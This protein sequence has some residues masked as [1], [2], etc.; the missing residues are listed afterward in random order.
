MKNR[1]AE[2]AAAK[3]D[4]DRTRAVMQTVLDNMGEGVMLFDADIRCQFANRQLMKL[5]ELPP[6]LGRPGVSLE[7]ITR[8]MAKRGDF[9]PTADPEATSRARL[10]FLLKESGIRYERRTPSGR[11]VEFTFTPLA[12]ESL[13]CVARDVTEVKQR[14]EALPAAADMLKLISRANFDLRAVLDTLVRTAARLC[15]ADWRRQHPARRRYVPPD[16][17][18]RLLARVRPSSSR[19]GC[20]S[21]RAP[22][23]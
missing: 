5:N 17:E 15:D 21:R 7:D 13:L 2:L 16:G 8:F 11:D 12:D 14:E 9:G 23:R 19:R 4:V 10:A 18:P 22:R 1:E 6:E 20:G 3:A